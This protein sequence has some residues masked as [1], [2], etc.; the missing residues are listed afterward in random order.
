MAYNNT[1]RK[2]ATQ[3]ELG[4]LSPRRSGKER[5]LDQTFLGLFVSFIL[6]IIHG[7]IYGELGFGFCG[8]AFALFACF[9]PLAKREKKRW[10]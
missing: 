7:H 8:D 6:Y 5:G 2:R 10:R 1:Q 3:T 9:N 4:L